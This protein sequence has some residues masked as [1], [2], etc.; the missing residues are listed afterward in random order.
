MI[1]KSG[2]LLWPTGDALNI[3]VRTASSIGGIDRPSVTIAQNMWYHL[4]MTVK[5]NNIVLYINGTSTATGTL[6]SNI[7]PVFRD[8][9]LGGFNG[10]LQNCKMCNYAIDSS[11]LSGIMGSH[12]EAD[13]N[14]QLKQI[15]QKI[16]C[17]GMPYNID[18]NPG[19]A[20]DMKSLL[21]QNK[22]DQVEKAFL[23]VKNNADAYLSGNTTAENKAAMDMCYGDVAAISAVAGNSTSC[24]TAPTCLPTA[25]FTCPPQ[26][27][28]N[29]FDIRTHKNFYKYVQVGNVRA[30]PQSNIQAGSANSANV[31]STAASITASNLQSSPYSDDLL[32]KIPDA[33]LQA[34]GLNPVT[35]TIDDI[36]NALKNNP[37]IAQ[38]LLT[39][40]MTASNKKANASSVT[41]SAMPPPTTNTLSPDSVKMYLQSNPSAAGD[42]LGDLVQNT[43]DPAVVQSVLAGL[44]ATQQVQMQDLLTHISPTQMTD[45]LK[46]MVQS[47]QLSAGS[48]LQIMKSDSRLLAAITG[49]IKDGSL[50]MTDIMSGLNDTPQLRNM[51][52][53]KMQEQ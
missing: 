43:K 15:F 37:Q 38:Q 28:V 29:D 42:L 26:K 50:S 41:P 52:A 53:Q 45:M 23:S 34:M 1:Q 3:A 18:N 27:D 46:A 8:M 35:A 44:A 49:M 9:K 31:A 11:E 48:V 30:P 33:S 24:K 51:L 2:I 17:A 40:G 47:G 4:C 12:P 20:Q 16:G 14:L 19:A 39:N 10:T 36:R 13:A 25:P 5:D 32:K 21:S 22:Q 7:Q 6:A